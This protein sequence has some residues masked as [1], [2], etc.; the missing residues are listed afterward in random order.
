MAGTISMAG[1][2]SGMDVNGMVTA[3]VNAEGINKTQL[4]GRLTSTN[5]ASTTISDISTLLSKLKTSVDAL[6]TP[7]K[8]QSYSATSSNTAISASIT[9]ST[10]AARYSVNVKALAQEYRAYTNT[11]SSL[12]DAIG[13]AGKMSI[14]VG[15]NAAGSI[16]VTSSDTLNTLVTKINAANLGV[17][18]STLYDGTNFRM[19]LRGTDTGANNAV[20]VSGV[21]LGLN[22]STNVKQQAQD[23]HV[24]LD[25]YDIYSHGN[26]VTGALPGV[27]L[28]L[29]GTTDSA[30]DIN[31]KSDSSGI[32]TKVQSFIDSYNSVVNKVH[33]TA[34]Y[35][36][37]K[38][39]IDALAGNSTLRSL[40]QGMSNAL[41]TA[42]NSGDSNYSTLYSLGISTQQDGTLTLDTDKLSKA[43]A[44]SPDAVTKLFAGTSSSNGVMDI[45]STMTQSFTDTKNG[46]LTNQ[47]NTF[48]ASA[49]RL[50]TS[51][52]NETT[53]LAKYK[54]RLMAQFANMDSIVSA[55][56]N[57]MTY[58]SNLSK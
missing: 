16:D 6:S 54:D 31:I 13:E 47:I 50:T 48:K 51:I 46:F 55:S 1:L 8:A 42:V 9:T 15:S 30:A 26:V 5:Q 49:T 52:D 39:T 33:S 18:A 22:V 20:T 3:I 35:G 21:D 36:T 56:N 58:L 32:Q 2:G 7:E 53:R 17:T 11:Q 23:A 44:T 37:T 41:H 10:T 29:S 28:T 38:G 40:T 57:T 45:M 43:I 14:Q 27:T 12:N 4:Q 25:G 34:G 19:Q 24:V